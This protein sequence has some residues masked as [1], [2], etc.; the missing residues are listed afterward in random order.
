MVLSTF[1]PE[2]QDT[3]LTDIYHYKDTNIPKDK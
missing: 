2:Y 1:I 3:K